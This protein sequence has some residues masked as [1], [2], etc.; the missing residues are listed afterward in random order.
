MSMT[1]TTLLRISMSLLCLAN[2]PPRYVV[3]AADE[4]AVVEEFVV[5]GYLPDYRAYINVNSTTLHLTDM[6][7]FSL[8]P[9]SILRRYSNDTVLLSPNQSGRCCLSSEHFD[10]TRKARAYKQEHQPTEQIRILVT[11]GGGGR[12]NGFHELVTGSGKLQRQFIQAL[13]DLWCVYLFELSVP[14]N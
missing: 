9:D 3:S 4:V 12:S 6:M 2:R 13:V 14:F 10:L 7:I 8:T 1:M 5:A 11:V